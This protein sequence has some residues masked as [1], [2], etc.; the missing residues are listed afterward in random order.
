MPIAPLVAAVRRRLANLPGPLRGSGEVSNGEPVMVELL[1]G[2]EW[3]DLAAD[4]YVLVRDDAGQIRITYG[5]QGGEGS[6]TERATATLQLRNT[7]GRFSPRNPSGPYYDVLNWRATQLRISVPDGLGGKSYRLWGEVSNWSTGWESSG[8]DVWVDVAINGPLQ[9]LAQAPAPE[10]STIYRAI[11]DPNLTGL[12]AYWPCEDASG[13]TSLASALT[14]GSPMTWTGTPALATYDGFGASDP[15]PTITGSTLTGGVAKYDTTSVTQYQVRYL[16]AVPA[17]GFSD[18]DVISRVQVTPAVAGQVEYLDIHYNNP[19]GAGSFG[20]R[21]TLSVQAY[22]TDG[23]PL[24]YSGEES[25]TLDVRGRLL[26]VSME[27]SNDGSNQDITLRVLDVETGVTDS[28]SI[29]TG[30]NVTRIRSISLG[31]AGIINPSD[32]TGGCT[33]AAVGHVT[34]QTTI[35]D[36]EDLGEAIDPEGETAG[37]RIQRLCGEEGIAFDWVGD[38]DDTV[39]LG[40]Q[41]KQNLL[42]LVQEACLADGGLLYENR[43]VLGLG[44]RTRASLYNQDPA[45]VLSYPGYN[46]AQT[47]VPVDDDRTT[48]NILTVTVGGVS[49]TY[50]ETDGPLGTATIGR[51]GETSGLTL[52]LATSDTPTLLDHAAWRV[53]LGTVDEA[54][55]PQISVNL[56]HSSITPDMR[57]AI[58]GLR[59]GDRIQITDPPDWLPPDTIDQLIL[60]MEE[61]ITRFEHRLSFICAPASPY[62]SVG[63]LDD[64]EARI[65]IDSVLV[66]AVSSSAT[67]LV[68]APAAGED[69]LWTTDSGDWPFDIRMGGEVMTVTA[70]SDWLS[71]T[72]ARTVAS[73]WGTADTGQAWSTG[74]G[75]SADYAVASGVGTHTLA[76][77]NASRRC[78]TD[79]T[80]TDVDMQGDILTG[81]AATGGSLFGG[82]SARYMDSSNF[83]TARLEFTTAN[84]LVL[85]LRKFVGA[86]ETQLAT[87][88]LADTYTPGSTW[89]RVRFQVQGAQLR[90]RAWLATGVEPAGSWQVTAT[91]SSHSTSAF[92]GTRSISSSANTNVNPVIS[93]DNLRVINPQTLTVTRSVNGVTKAH[94]ANADLSL[95]YP[96]YIAL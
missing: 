60:G 66:S 44:Y 25:I 17:A 35:T 51:Y 91:D 95:A 42:S 4:G 40:P 89:V 37:R 6:Q 43:Q 32:G 53:H 26:R 1:V 45:L 54:R 74:G 86:V 3:V 57:R 18:L 36:I 78:F 14:S 83:Y 59:L 16:L 28:T 63:V 70:V 56:A 84:A 34:V 22:D 12:V 49:A 24:A 72:F 96:T 94:T 64:P 30:A 67:S 77:T 68:V 19:T 76:T 93:Y 88:S 87:F 81:A 61:S 29:E 92:L 11:T 31:P 27:A 5:I 52:N 2:G 8:N 47:P 10:R 90:A 21:G 80:F 23:A 20:G 58:L 79:A 55:F 82:L 73:G 15:L 46:L 39:P 13:A 71:D 33:G 50:E 69:L 75:T 85:S 38:L 7:D 65:D 41:P 48:Q 9:R 62:S